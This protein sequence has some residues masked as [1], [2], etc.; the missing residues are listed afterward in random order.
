MYTINCHGGGMQL[1]HTVSSRLYAQFWTARI[2]LFASKVFF[3]FIVTQCRRWLATT[4]TPTFILISLETLCVYTHEDTVSLS[5]WVVGCLWASYS[6]V[7]FIFNTV[8][9]AAFN[10]CLNIC[11]LELLLFFVCVCVGGG[12]VTNS[13]MLHIVHVFYSVIFSDVDDYSGKLKSSY[14]ISN[15]FQWCKFSG[16][17]RNSSQSVKSGNFRQFD[18]WSLASLIF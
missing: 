5:Y 16:N 7:V 8:Q 2:P 15:I 6:H 14:C 12:A 17:C 18:V 11:M 10:I 3:K 13:K 4:L 1:P 9:H